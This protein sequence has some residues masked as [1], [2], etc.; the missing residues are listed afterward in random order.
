MVRYPFG[1]Y[2]FEAALAFCVYQFALPV[3]KGW[4]SFAPEIMMGKWCLSL[5]TRKRRFS[6]YGFPEYPW[7][8][9]KPQVSAIDSTS[10]TLF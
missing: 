7:C 4:E 9:S 6:E 3:A 2:R 1:K 10:L 5:I 8:K